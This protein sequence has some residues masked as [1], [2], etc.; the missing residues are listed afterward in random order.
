MKKTLVRNIL[1]LF[2]N[3]KEEQDES[4]PEKFGVGHG[5]VKQRANYASVMKEGSL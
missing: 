2:L 5:L 1:E 4:A 3:D